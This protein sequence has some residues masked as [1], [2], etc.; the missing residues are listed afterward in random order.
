MFK[1]LTEQ[2][3]LRQARAE[4]AELLAKNQTLEEAVLELAEL[5]AENKDVKNG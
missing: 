3:Q 1:K 5:V 2:E 4:N